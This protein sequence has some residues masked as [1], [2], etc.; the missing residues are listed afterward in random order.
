MSLADRLAQER[1][2]RMAA[3]RLLEQRTRDLAA[4]EARLAQHAKGLF[5]RIIAEREVSQSARSQVDGL[6]GQTARITAD[7]D[8]AQTTAVLAERRLWG[9]I[10]A[11]RDGFALL[12]DGLR[13]VGVNRAFRSFLRGVGITAGEDFGDVLSAAVAA[14]ICD[15]APDLQGWRQAQDTPQAPVTLTRRDGISLQMIHHRTPAG[16][17]IVLLQDITHDMRIRAAIEALPDGFVLFDRDERLIMANSAY[18]AAIPGAEA[19]TVPGA[20]LESILRA[21]LAHD[22]FMRIDG[23]DEEWVQQRLSYHR[24]AEGEMLLQL[25]D[26]R[27]LMKMDRP[28]PDG[29]RV[30]LRM[31]V[32]EMKAK[33]AALDA[34]RVAAEAASRAKSAFLANMSH[35]IRTPMNGVIGMADLLCDTPLNDEQRLFAETIKSSGEALLVIINDILDYS[36]I[37]A[38][39]LTLHPE[40]FDLERTIHQVAML[41]AP[42]A[43]EKGID[44]AIDYDIFTPTQLVADPG[45]IR[46]ILTNIMGNAVKFTETGHVLVR[47]VGIDEGPRTQAIHLT[48]E[49]TGIG[50]AQENLAHVFGEFNQV[51]EQANRKFEGTGLGL[52]IARRL[53]QAMGGDIWVDSELG[54]GSSFGLRLPLAVAQEA[55]APDPPGAIRHVLVVD[56]Q[57]INRTILERQIAPCGVSVTLARSGDEALRA[58][59]TTP[60]IDAVLTDHNMPEMSGLDLVVAMRAAGHRMPVLLLSSSPPDAH[61]HAALP[62]IAGFLPKPILRADLYKRLRALTRPTEV[63]ISTPQTRPAAA[64]LSGRAMR[65]LAAEDNRTNQLVFRKMLADSGIDLRFA[66]NGLI[67][68]EMFQTFDPDLIFMDISM[69]E[70]DGRQAAQAIR[71][72]ERETGGHV[73]IIAVTAHAMDGDADG[74]L[75]AGIDHYMTKPLRKS[76]L[77]ERLAEHRPAGVRPITDGSAAA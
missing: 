54:K 47:V 4:A 68:V 50:I 77:L 69:P 53:V 24:R 44:L 73:P 5:E 74:I 11:L 22:A 35:E 30:C 60:G 17:A 67:A 72:L 38:E 61:D 57:L 23:T 16:D 70:M 45:R 18:V 40:P 37:E 13:I 71:R 33:E 15:A 56:D 52:A 62:D 29:G 64:P 27:W 2:G 76:D 25:R 21:G 3:E 8:R 36:K 1:R 55:T 42:R 43:R 32:T 48:I 31:D 14:G 12:D 63:P 51:E 49:D 20:T 7:L 59:A 39:R 75:A 19:A 58:L 28:I 10:D 66:D 6:M 46:Q 34:A 41:L 26:G 9:S 65:V